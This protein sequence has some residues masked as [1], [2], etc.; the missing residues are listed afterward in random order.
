MGKL[1]TATLHVL[2]RSRTKRCSGQ[3]RTK[4]PGTEETAA[5]VINRQQQVTKSCT[6]R[7]GESER[8]LVMHARCRYSGRINRSRNYS[9]SRRRWVMY[10][11]GPVTK[12]WKR[13]DGGRKDGQDDKRVKCEPTAATLG[14]LEKMSASWYPGRRLLW[15]AWGTAGTGL[16]RFAIV[17]VSQ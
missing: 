4:K 12:M 2:D 14:F 8:V 9:P 3:C 5:G 15:P 1:S 13:K 17:Q 6:V 16:S 7:I 10:G 11:A